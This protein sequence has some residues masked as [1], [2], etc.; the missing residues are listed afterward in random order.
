MSKLAG[1]LVTTWTWT[2]W[3]TR[4]CPVVYRY[5]GEGKAD[6]QMSGH[7]GDVSSLVSLEDRDI[8]SNMAL[9]SDISDQNFYL[10]I[11]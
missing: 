2:Q 10:N 6:G 4:P 7:R 5:K 3:D 8:Y 11:V 1:K 9:Q